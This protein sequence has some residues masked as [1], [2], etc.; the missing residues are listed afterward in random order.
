VKTR[1]DGG[2]LQREASAFWYDYKTKNQTFTMWRES[3]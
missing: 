2:A 3:R 1:F